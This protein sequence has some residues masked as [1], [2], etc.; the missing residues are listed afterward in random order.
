LSGLQG[1]YT[2]VD[3]AAQAVANITPGATG[4]N[5]TLD[6]FYGIKTVTASQKGSG[7]YGSEGITFTAANV[8]LNETRA[9]GFIVLTTDSGAVGSATN[10]ENAS[11]A[12][13][14]VSGS[15]QEADIVRQV[16]TDRYRINTNSTGDKDISELTARLKTTGVASGSYED[17]SGVDMN[18]WAFDQ[19]GGSY[20]VKKLTARKAVVVPFACDRLTKSAG[21]R[22]PLNDDGSP[23]QV[24]WKFFEGQANASAGYVKIENA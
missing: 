11:I 4:A 6:I 7:Y 12:Y 16:S 8:G 2:A 9:S 17:G 15:L 14:Y 23:R 19:D 22:F 13:A 10:Q 5:A 1:D 20:L 3:A 24:P 21:T 18:I